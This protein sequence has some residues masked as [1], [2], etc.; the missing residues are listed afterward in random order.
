MISKSRAIFTPEFISLTQFKTPYIYGFS[1]PQKLS[2]KKLPSIGECISKDY[3]KQSGDRAK[4]RMINLIKGNINHYKEQPVFL[5]LTFADNLI[6]LKKANYEFKKFVLRFNYYLGYNLSYVAV[7]EFQ[8]RGAVHYHMLILNIPFIKGQEIEKEIWRQGATDIRLVR[9]QFGLFNYLTKYFSKSF[10]DFRFMHHKRYLY[11]FP[12]QL[13]IVR[14][15]IECNE[16]YQEAIE[17][18]ELVNKFK[19][20]I[21]DKVGNIINTINREE[22]LIE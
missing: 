4:S 6:D 15:E 19:F 8:E 12:N 11:S 20:D 3:Q 2:V 10:R 17:K 21:K 13:E 16:K 5:T 18:G 1:L 22:Y 7:P 9:R 14:D